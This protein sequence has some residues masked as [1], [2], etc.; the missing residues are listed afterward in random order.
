MLDQRISPYS[1]YQ[2]DSETGK[3]MTYG[4]LYEYAVALSNG[5]QKVGLAKGDVVVVCM[6]NCAEYAVATLGV[7]Q[8]GG[9]ISGLD[10]HMATGIAR[11]HAENLWTYASF[12]P[13][14]RYGKV[15]STLRM[16]VRV[17]YSQAVKRDLGCC[18][19]KHH[20]KGTHCARSTRRPFWLSLHL[21][22]KLFIIDHPKQDKK[23]KSSSSKIRDW[24]SLFLSGREKQELDATGIWTKSDL[25]MLSYETC[26]D[27][28][29]RGIMLSHYNVVAALQLRCQ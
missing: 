22:Q 13:F 16:Q 5:L 23:A 3:R 17:Y 27:G 7:L 12:H 15:L 10:H 28:M 1:V 6:P 9:I 18:K 25:A 19:R 14:R 8:C 21:L 26:P 24:N 29:E 20:D 2:I 11:C 4:D